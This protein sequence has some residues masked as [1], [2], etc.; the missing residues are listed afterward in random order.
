MSTGIRPLLVLFALAGLAGLVLAA[1]AGGQGATPPRAETVSHISGKPVPRF[2]A[3]RFAAVN[4]R[5]G[6]STDHPILWRYE[7]AG[8]PVLIVKESYGWRRVRDPDGDEVWVHAR[9]LSD[10]ERA[11]LRAETPLRRRPAMDAPARA[12]LAVGLLVEVERCEAGWCRVEAERREGWVPAYRLWGVS[13][14]AP[15]L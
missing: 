2:E 5:M 6:P 1:P 9:M 10:A 13:P 3:L 7:R 11:M 8:L 14:E 12:R 15:P 4:G